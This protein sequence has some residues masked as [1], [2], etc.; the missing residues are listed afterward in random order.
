MATCRR[1]K[2][3]SAFFR[4]SRLART[5][6]PN[7]ADMCVLCS[8]RSTQSSKKNLALP[9]E[10]TGAQPKGLPTYLHLNGLIFPTIKKGFGTRRSSEGQTVFF[11]TEREK[12]A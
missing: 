3:L 11:R 10:N 8:T 9:Y 6:F 4:S 5:N 12:T 2:A 7:E 1:E